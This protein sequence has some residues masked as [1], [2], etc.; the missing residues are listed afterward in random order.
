[1]NSATPFGGITRHVNN[2]QDF[3]DRAIPAKENDVW[4]SLPSGEEK[5][6]ER[7]GEAVCFLFD[8]V[9]ASINSRP[10]SMAQFGR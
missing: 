2:V 6:L 8:L 5:T 10:K 1:M 9:K 7:S 4:K 3:H